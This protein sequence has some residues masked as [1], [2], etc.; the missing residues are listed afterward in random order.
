M[1]TANLY[2]NY[3][4][5]NVAVKNLSII[6]E[7]VPIRYKEPCSVENPVLSFDRTKVW[8][9]INDFNY[10]YLISSPT[11]KIKSRIKVN[12]RC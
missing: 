12:L 5:D 7:D 3:S 8:K 2:T 10:F 9:N 11:K 1:P 4:D 6:E